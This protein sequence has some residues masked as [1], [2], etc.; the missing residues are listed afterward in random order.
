LDE[1]AIFHAVEEDVDGA[2]F[3]FAVGVIDEFE[4]VGFALRDELAEDDAL[5]AG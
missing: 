5:F 4:A 3:E 1:A 2:A